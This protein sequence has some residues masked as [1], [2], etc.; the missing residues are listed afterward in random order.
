MFPLFTENF[1][2][3]LELTNSGRYGIITTNLRTFFYSETIKIEKGQFWVILRYKKKT[4]LKYFRAGL[5]C[6]KSEEGPVE[7]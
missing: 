6:W 3:V 4:Y 5:K 2:P 7:P 1:I